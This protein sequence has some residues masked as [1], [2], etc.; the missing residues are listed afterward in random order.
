LEF[1]FQYFLINK[2]ALIDCIEQ[3]N[4]DDINRTWDTLDL[5]KQNLEKPSFNSLF[6][7][8]FPIELD[9]YTKEASFMGEPFPEEFYVLDMHRYNGG[10]DYVHFFQ[11]CF[12]I[13]DY[14]GVR[15]EIFKNLK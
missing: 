8:W 10:I 11:N 2:Q 15:N 7:K 3:L 13:A 12:E 6:E 9:Y 5:L 4:Q 1:S 14:W